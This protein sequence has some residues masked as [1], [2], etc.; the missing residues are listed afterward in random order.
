MS[1]I[2]GASREARILFCNCTY[3][4]V[5]PEDVKREVLA[6]LSS[7]DIAFDAVADLCEMSARKDPALE[8]L[9]QSPPLKIIACYPR[10]VRWLFHA[11]E[12]P[13]PEQGIEVLNMREDNAEEIFDEALSPIVDI[14]KLEKRATPAKRATPDLG[15][16]EEQNAQESA[17]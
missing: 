4:K 3:S 1:E 5:V 14:V 8:R 7:S 12:T 10:A 11:A 15:S 2:K 16:K 6:R 13:L 17:P 9:A